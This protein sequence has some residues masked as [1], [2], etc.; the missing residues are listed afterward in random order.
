MA[1]THSLKLSSGHTMPVVGFGI[2][3]VP[4][5]TTADAV[6]NA[7]K[8]GYRH[9]D[10]A[11]DYTNSAEAGVGVRKAIADGLVKREELFITSK[12]WNNY[13]AREHAIEMAHVE[14]ENWGVG[15]LD[16]FLIHFPIAQRHIP[17]SELKWPCFWS[18]KEQTKVTEQVPVPI[19]ETWAALETLVKTD[20]NPSGILHSIG[21]ANFN[22]QLVYDLLRSAKIHPAVNQ[23]E[24][25]PYLVQPN[26]ITMLQENNIVVTA[27]SSFGPQSFVELDNVRAVDAQPLFEH[28]AVT[29]IAE[30][31]GKTPAQVLLRWATQRDIIVIPKS[32]SSERLAQNL[33]STDFELTAEELASISALDKGL[34]FNDPSDLSTPIRI[35]A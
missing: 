2:W 25:H 34:R 17:M 26:L 5:E 6:Y 32:N 7:I 9:I 27:Y 13:H 18:D 20:S 23:I 4:R 3:K 21:V 16:L 28:N 22:A 8:L 30:K 10:G 29:T 1:K 33:A 35:F 15:Y 31:H 14:N 11:H 12:L 24:H 19:A